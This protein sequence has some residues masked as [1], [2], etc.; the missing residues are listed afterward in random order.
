M[1]KRL[2][3]KS[4][5]LISFT[6]AIFTSCVNDSY[7]ANPPAV[8]NQS[9]TE[10]FDTAAAAYNRG[11]RFVNRSEPVGITDFGNILDVLNLPFE[12]YSSKAR[13]NGYLWAD[14]LSTSADAGVISSFAVSPAVYMK[15]GDKITFYTR[16]QIYDDGAG[17]STDYANRLQV[18]IN[19]TNTG[20]NC[21]KG[22][23]AG[24]YS[25]VILDVNPF[26]YPFKLTEFNSGAAQRKGAYPH[27]WTRYTA[28]VFG[29]NKPVWGRF[30]FRY[31]VEGGGSNGLGSG[32]GIDSVAYIAQ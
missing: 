1:R 30:A 15:N 12:A 5:L 8:P 20:L 32:V 10:E 21:G 29:L 11:W 16:A 17:D 9:F 22:L 7:L 24:D 14:Y 28:T 31:F 23:D 25:Q 13:K 2:L 26:L 18:C 3:S 6:A 19:T 4:L 27:R